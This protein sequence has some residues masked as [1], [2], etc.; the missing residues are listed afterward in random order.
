LRDRLSQRHLGSGRLETSGLKVKSR[1]VRA[2]VLSRAA[3]ILELLE[4][5]YVLDDTCTGSPISEAPIAS[6]PKRKV[7]VCTFHAHPVA[8]SLFIE[9]VLLA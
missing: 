9:L 4:L 3:S 7:Q 1:S 8:N 5:I 2:D 6:K